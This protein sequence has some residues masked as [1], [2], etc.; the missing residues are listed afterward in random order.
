MPTPR[1]RR[2]GRERSLS[3]D[4]PVLDAPVRAVVGT[5]ARAPP[6]TTLSTEAQSGA[7]KGCDPKAIR[8]HQ[9]AISMQSACNQK[10]CDPKAMRKRGSLV[11]P[12]G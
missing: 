6:R 2:P 5:A 12:Q 9:I 10:G 4:A 1:T 8:G 11:G 7:E 3:V